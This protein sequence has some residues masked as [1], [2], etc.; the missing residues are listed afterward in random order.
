MSRNLS[1]LPKT[2]SAD[3]PDAGYRAR[4]L[5]VEDEPVTLEFMYELLGPHYTVQ[6]VPDGQAALDAIASDPLPDLI[7]SDLAMP[8]LDGLGLLRAVRADPRTARIPVVLITAQ[9]D[10]ATRLMGLE[11]QVDDFIGKPVRR[12]E[13][14]ARVRGALAR[15]RAAR[16]AREQ[17]VRLRESEGRLSA[18][19]AQAAAGISEITLEGQFLHVNDQLCRMLGRT[20]QELLAAGVSAVTHPEDERSTLRAFQGLVET[21]VPVAIDKRYLHADGTVIWANSSLTRLDDGWGRARGVLAVT[22]DI[23]GRVQAERALRGAVEGLRTLSG[24]GGGGALA[25]LTVDEAGTIASWSRGA[26]ETYGY[27]AADIVGRPER[28]LFTPATLAAAA[29][30][31]QAATAL[32]DGHAACGGWQRRL[33][34]SHF[35]CAGTMAPLHERGRHTGF[36]KVLREVDGNGQG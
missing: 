16:A 33:D 26:E 13:L 34:G 29:W 30:E 25:V 9:D 8:R 24:G 2:P 15:A 7:L 19:F 20:R 28:V 1:N 10:E 31:E 21:G 32:R 5:M 11:Q 23:S 4:I 35:W 14:Y 36:L 12:R 18:V 3:D 17:E 27:G 22:I 6:T